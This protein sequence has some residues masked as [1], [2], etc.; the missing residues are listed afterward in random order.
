VLAAAII[1]GI[2]TGIAGAAIGHG[3]YGLYFYDVPDH[4]YRYG[5]HWGGSVLANSLLIVLVSDRRTLSAR[6]FRRRR[7][8]KRAGARMP[9]W[10]TM[11]AGSDALPK[12][13]SK[14]LK[15]PGTRAP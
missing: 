6:S 14:K 3:P 15:P 7:P 12:A 5:P 11:M 8:P 4:V 2:A 9:P 10:R 13:A 1:R